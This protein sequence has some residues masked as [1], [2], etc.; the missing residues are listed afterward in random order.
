MSSSVATLR[1]RPFVRSLAP[2]KTS[3]RSLERRISL[4]WGLLVLNVLTFTPNT[5]I[6]HI[7][8]TLGKVI[9]QGS[10]TAAL[11]VILT[12][13]RRLIIRPNFF[14]CLPSLLVIEA[15]LTL[16]EAQFL[17]GAAYRV[18]R[19]TEFVAALWLLT[20]FWGRR[21]LLLVRCH[22]KAMTIV[23]VSVAVGII[24]APGKSRDAGRLQGVIWPIPTTQVAH[25]AA[26]T[27]GLVAVLWF[28]GYRRNRP[29]A[30]AIVASGAILIL[31][32]TRTAL[33]GLLAGVLVAGLSLI[34]TE[35]RVRRLF[36]AAGAAA[37][38]AVLALSGPITT[39]LVRGE[40]TRQLT[41]LSGRTNF[42]GPVLAFPR[43]K[44]EEIFGFGLSNAQFGGLPIDSNWIASYQEQG[45]FGIVICASMLVF[46]FVTAFFQPRGVQRAAALFLVTYCLVASFTEVG[47]TDASTYLLDMTVAASLLVPAVVSRSRH[48]E[49]IEA[50]GLRESV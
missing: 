7:P 39:W 19:L 49:R 20:P 37:A 22:L 45:L 18:F 34:V 36:A 14:L 13:N 28:C 32:H 38:V 24:I 25:Y 33:V 21:D 1:P 17:K 4:A 6:L 26:V 44:F 40:G 35:A 11:L 3:E 5:S 41:N 31:T 48:R 9:T 8:S 2:V 10:L 12:V 47:F 23:L 29:A 50:N 27:L 42:W 16:L 15:I 43:N 30:F 46:L